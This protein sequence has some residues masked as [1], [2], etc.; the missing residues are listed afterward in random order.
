M[1]NALVGAYLDQ[2]GLSLDAIAH[3][4]TSASPTDMQWLT[5]QD[6]RGRLGID[7]TVLP[8]LVDSPNDGI[9]IHLC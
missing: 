9:R 1:A 4:I 3:S 6:A 7:F 8:Q 2:L 5:P